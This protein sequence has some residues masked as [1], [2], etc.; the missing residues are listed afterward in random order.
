MEDFWELR[1]LGFVFIGVFKTFYLHWF[2]R[3]M[4]LDH[5]IQITEDKLYVLVLVHKLFLYLLYLKPYAHIIHQDLPDLGKYTH[6]LDIY[7]Y[8]S[9]TIQYPR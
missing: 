5:F 1:G 6:D 3:F 9:F 8:G 4:L 2:I 7:R